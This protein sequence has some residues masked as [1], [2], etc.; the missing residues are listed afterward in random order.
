MAVGRPVNIMKNSGVA[1]IFYNLAG[2]RP[3]AYYI[4]YE[5]IHDRIAANGCYISVLQPYANNII[6]AGDFC[7]KGIT[8]GIMFTKRD[9]AQAFLALCRTG[10][11]SADERGHMGRILSPQAE[12]I[13]P[14]AAGFM[15]SYPKG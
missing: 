15:V 9:K 14:A 1:A 6:I 10:L 11:P 12:R 13:V 5:C 3:R 2:L 7:K 8:Y 4:T